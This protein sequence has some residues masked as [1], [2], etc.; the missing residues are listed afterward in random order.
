MAMLLFDDRRSHAVVAK[1]AADQRP[2]LDDLARHSG[3]RL[4]VFL[5]PE[6]DVKESADG[7]VV[8]VSGPDVVQNPSL[9]V[10]ARFD[11][12]ANQLPGIVFFGD[13]D[14]HAFTG[15]RGVYW[16]LGLDLFSEEGRAAEAAFAELF[17]T[18][19]AARLRAEDETVDIVVSL[20]EALSD[21][22]RSEAARPLGA[23]MGKGVLRIVSYPGKLL[24]AMLVAF[25][26][27]YG[28]GLAN[29]F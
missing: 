29:K 23:S 8:A 7:E 22:R 5:P 15:S 19:R 21:F 27:A 10:A 9:E 6:V 25:G 4:F 17:A 28:T 14:F 13:V 1:F 11:I 12:G 24:E 3:L 26:T 16:P 2:W 18:V 20:Q